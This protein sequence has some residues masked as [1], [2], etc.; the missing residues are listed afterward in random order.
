MRREAKKRKKQSADKL[1]RNQ[2]KQFTRRAQG[3]IKV[4]VN[5]SIT[6]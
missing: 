6:S 3:A 1:N 5:D 2:I 4:V